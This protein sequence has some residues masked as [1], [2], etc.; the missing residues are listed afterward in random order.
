MVIHATQEIN[1]SLDEAQQRRVAIDYLRNA[2]DWKE[3]YYVSEDDGW[4]YDDKE[5]HTTHSFNVQ[6]KVRKANR[7]DLV[8]NNIIKNHL[9]NI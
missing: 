5:C 8:L 6:V 4:V 7:E 1:V 2:A 3:S 9:F